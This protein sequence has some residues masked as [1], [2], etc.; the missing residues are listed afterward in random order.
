MAKKKRKLAAIYEIDDQNFMNIMG[1]PHYNIVDIDDD[2]VLATVW[3]DDDPT[4]CE[5]DAL[6][7]AASED[8]LHAAE[9]ALKW[10]Q[11]Q[12]DERSPAWIKKL[13][14]AVQK[15]NE[16]DKHTQVFYD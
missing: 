2:E 11:D 12:D 14:T 13:A 8:L 1:G 10:A 16:G 4:K 3:I 7:L 6:L 9:A 15:A 5:Q